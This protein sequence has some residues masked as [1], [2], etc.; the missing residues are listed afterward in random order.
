MIDCGSLSAGAF[1]ES[2]ST[3]VLKI[4][5]VWKWKGARNKSRKRAEKKMNN[6]V[7]AK[8]LL[9]SLEGF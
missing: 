2:F 5:T 6:I 4:F 7:K 9:V 1:L 3:N 8:A